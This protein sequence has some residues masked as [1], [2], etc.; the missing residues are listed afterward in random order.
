MKRVAVLFGGMST[1]HLVSC[2]SAFSII[3]GLREAK[4]E[5]YPI[6]LTKQGQFLPWTLPDE[7]ILELDWEERARQVLQEQGRTVHFDYGFDPRQLWMQLI[8]CQPD[9]VFP[10][11]HGI[12]CED[13]ALQGFLEWTGVPYVG[14]RV[15]ASAL[16]MEKV[17]TKQILRQAG[18]PVVP[19]VWVRRQEWEGVPLTDGILQPEGDLQRENLA[20][21][22]QQLL[23][24]LERE[25]GYPMFLKPSS[26]GS[27]VGTRPAHDR[28]GLRE[29][30]DEVAQYCVDILVESF[31]DAREL[32]VAI[33]GNREAI[34]APVGE[35]LVKD[36]SEYYDYHT[37]YF[38][39][40]ASEARLPA[41]LSPE[42]AE[43]LQ[44]LAL[45]AYRVLGC[46][47]LSRVDFFLDRQTGSLYLN[48]INTLPG[49]TAISLY[50][51]AF[52][53]TGKFL[54][55]LVR[56]LCLLALEEWE[57]TRRIEGVDV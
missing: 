53:L 25:L 38:S 43:K 27:S 49:F 17:Y 1:E 51:Q 39:Q 23:E 34:P 15:L 47:G 11:V 20:S 52:A 35:I 16:G 5:V 32:E 3:Q 57:Q 50:P 13:G 44:N 7:G 48:E 41:D 12:N 40:T 33:L 10:A 54:P 31:V 2:R 26:G 24:R 21:Q 19:S 37:K 22:Q 9:V 8:G 28:T 29:A 42:L 36:E 14:S 45:Q 4:L 30:L 6:G 46:R 55:D 18:I 56:T